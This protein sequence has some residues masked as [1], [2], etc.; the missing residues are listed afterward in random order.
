MFT[1]HRLD[2]LPFV[3]FSN[4]SLLSDTIISQLT[5]RIKEIVAAVWQKISDFFGSYHKPSN[6]SNIKTFAIISCVSLIALLVISML[7]RR[8]SNLVPP[9]TPQSH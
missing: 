7:R 8:D 4:S 2:L 3:T 6:E 9:P 1:I 5:Q